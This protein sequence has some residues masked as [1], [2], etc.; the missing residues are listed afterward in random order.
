MNVSQ[1]VRTICMSNKAAA[2]D[3]SRD[4]DISPDGSP[5][6]FQNRVITQRINA[7][8]AAN[9]DGLG[10]GEL[11]R[12]VQSLEEYIDAHFEV[13]EMYMERSG[14][15]DIMTHKEEHARF[16]RDILDLKTKLS[17]L[18]SGGEFAAL[19]DAE[20]KGRFSAWLSA[21]R[22]RFDDKLIAFMAGNAETAGKNKGIPSL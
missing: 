2:V 16:I 3:E 8:Q 13:E 20:M 21:H 6:T 17:S 11:L 5:I 15:P 4:H 9:R 7:I 22:E 19:L 14:Y 10:R 18:T 12:K 1:D